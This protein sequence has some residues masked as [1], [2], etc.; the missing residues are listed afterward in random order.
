[1]NVKN[2]MIFKAIV[3]FVCLNQVL[4]NTDVKTSSGVVRGQTVRVV[5]QN[6]NQYLSVPYAEPPVGPLRFARPKP[7]QKPLPVRIKMYFVLNFN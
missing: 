2:T 1:M 3:V 6:I 5:N 7:L 4:C